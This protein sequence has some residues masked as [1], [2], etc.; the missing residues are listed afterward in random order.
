M[1]DK[2]LNKLKKIKEPFKNRLFFV[3][4]LTEKSKDYNIKPILV[5]RNAVEFYTLGSYSTEDID[6][7][8]KLS[9]L[10]CI[11]HSLQKRESTG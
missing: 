8:S 7:S 2:L 10:P 9:F 6:I 3:G 5:G 1:R 4:I 11:C